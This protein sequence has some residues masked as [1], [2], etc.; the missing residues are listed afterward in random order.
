MHL[1]PPSLLRL[2]P[3]NLLLPRICSRSDSIY[4]QLAQQQQQQPA[5]PIAPG[6]GAT[7]AA[8]GLDLRGDPRSAAIR[9][10]AAHNPALLQQLI[11]QLGQS[12]PHL[13]QQLAT[14]PEAILDLL[15]GEGGP[16]VGDDGVPIPP[17][18]QVLSVTP[19]ERDAIER[20]KF[21]FAI[22]LP[23]YLS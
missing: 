7:P 1:P 2:H 4:N 20:V 9:E 16:A 18:A 11:Q 21:T 8:A 10:L 17:G 15:G 22:Y 14:N 3:L 12:N 23:E 6:L 5:A 13:L 19:E